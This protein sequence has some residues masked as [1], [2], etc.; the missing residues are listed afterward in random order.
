MIDPGGDDILARLRAETREAHEAIERDLAWETR[1]STRE[2]YR[3]L[4]ARFWGFHAA[5]EPALAEVLA[6]DAFFGPRR[7]LDRL[8]AD[9][10]HLGL[11]DA[12]IRALPRPAAVPPRD[13]AEA[14]G[15]LYVLEG[16][17]LGGQVIARHVTQQ[18]G[19][20][21]EDGCRYYRGH[22]RD[23][24]AMW[25][26][27]RLRLAEEAGTNGAEAIVASATRTFDTMRLWLCAPSDPA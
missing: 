19:L 14:F 12:A 2:G 26:A 24:G 25:K 6:D 22:G 1:V 17:T 9:L 16:S 4:L 15:S 7:R 10:H 8:T 21:G 27:F 5:W 13:R 3:G 23:T 11:D 20:T 18:L